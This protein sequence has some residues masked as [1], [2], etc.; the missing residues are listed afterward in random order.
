M[1]MEINTKFQ[2]SNPKTQIKIVGRDF[3]LETWSLEFG[4]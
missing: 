2:M 4:I 3:T 1:S